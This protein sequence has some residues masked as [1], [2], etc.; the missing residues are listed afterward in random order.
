V[1]YAGANGRPYRSIGKALIDSG[2]ITADEMSLQ[3]IRK[4]LESH[5][6]KRDETMWYNESYVFFKWV[7]EGPLGSLDTVLT[8]GRSIATDP[9]FHPRASLAFLVSQEPRYDSSGHV[10]GWDR[11]GRWVLN[12]DTGGAIKGPGRVDLFCGTGEAAEKMAGPMKQPG[13]LYYF[14]KKKR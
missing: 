5:P 3:A 6:E 4:Y 9:K 2:A 11:I 10:E 1:G 13:E 7:S 14:I 12:Q 8:A